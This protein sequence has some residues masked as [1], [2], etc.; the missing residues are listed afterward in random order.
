MGKPYGH[1]FGDGGEPKISNARPLRRRY[2]DVGLQSRYKWKLIIENMD[3]LP[4]SNLHGQLF[5]HG[6]T[7]AQELRP[8]SSAND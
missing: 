4:L 7:G 6:G 3:P 1:S 2:E 5:V 8:G